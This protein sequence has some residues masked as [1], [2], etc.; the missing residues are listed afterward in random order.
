M[1]V[2]P[3]RNVRVSDELWFAAQTEAV[4]RAETV[5]DVINRALTR[6]TKTPV[7][8]VRRRGWD[9]RH[10]ALAIENREATRQSP[11]AGPS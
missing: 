2:T 5:T 9:N 4:R 3:M 8:Q 1:A 11:S 6:Y 10:T 7:A